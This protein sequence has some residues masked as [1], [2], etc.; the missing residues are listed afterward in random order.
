MHK[1]QMDAARV[2]AEVFLNLLT[3]QTTTTKQ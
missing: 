3:T 1:E 2:A